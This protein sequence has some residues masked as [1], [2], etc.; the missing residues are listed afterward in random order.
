MERSLAKR[1]KATPFLA[2]TVSL[3][4]NSYRGPLRC[5]STIARSAH[6]IW[7]TCVVVFLLTQPFGHQ[8]CY[9]RRGES[10]QVRNV[11]VCVGDPIH[12]TSHEFAIIQHVRNL[13]VHCGTLRTHWMEQYLTTIVD[14]HVCDRFPR[15]W[16]TVII[17]DDFARGHCIHT[18]IHTMHTISDIH[19][20]K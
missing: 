2:S 8:P 17:E 1:C 16:I 6:C 15:N 5:T 3:R 11:C 7:A 14:L 13:V 10:K 12:G 18:P 20:Q 4:P 19:A 9:V